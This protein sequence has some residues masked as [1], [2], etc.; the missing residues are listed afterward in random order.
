M[1]KTSMETYCDYCGDTI[2][3]GQQGHLIVGHRD[4]CN[5]GCQAGYEYL[6]TCG[7]V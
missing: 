4:F 7:E 6:H 1:S 5:E 3:Q 2:I